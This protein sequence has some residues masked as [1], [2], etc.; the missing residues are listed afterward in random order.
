MII[1]FLISGVIR[2]NEKCFLFTLEHLKKQFS[3]FEIKIFVSTWEHVNTDFIKD[4]VDYINILP[5]PEDDFLYKHIT[6][7][8]QQQRQLHPQ[9][10]DWTP[11]MYKMFQGFK[12]LAKFI[13]SN[14]LLQE[15]DIIVRL[16]NDTIINFQ[17][18]ITPNLINKLIRNKNILIHTNFSDQRFSD[19]FFISTYNVYKKVTHFEDFKDYNERLK[20]SRNAEGFL[21]NHIIK[22]KV[23]PILIKSN[24]FIIKKFEDENNYKKR[25]IY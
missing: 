9:I 14:N 10:E 19:W 25:N 8:T 24:G 18:R 17:K 20:K 15:E 4:K 2:P 3:E 23:K 12:E 1:N 7:R 16:R 6:E 11:K 21:W 22:N 5:E 13:D